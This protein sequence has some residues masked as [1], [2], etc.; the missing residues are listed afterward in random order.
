MTLYMYS[1]HAI[2]HLC[3]ISEHRRQL[4]C[5]RYNIYPISCFITQGE[6]GDNGDQGD[7]GQPG[8]PGNDGEDGPRGFSG[9][10]GS[11]GPPGDAGAPGKPGTPVIII[12]VQNCIEGV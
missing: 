5:Q 10:R 3:I 2:I 6:P 7:I 1:P 8:V 12:Q 9:R 11:T 4:L